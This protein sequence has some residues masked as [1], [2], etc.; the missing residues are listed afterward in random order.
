V[1]ERF[2]GLP[3]GAT[4]DDAGGEDEAFLA[5]WE[6]VRETFSTHRGYLEAQ[7]LRSPDGRRVAVVHWSSPLM[8][9]RTVREEGD[10]IA[11]L[12]F[13]ADPALYLRVPA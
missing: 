3:P 7:A 2:A 5:A 12:P 11:A 13:A 6:P 8:Y 1:R 10:L 9:A 4:P